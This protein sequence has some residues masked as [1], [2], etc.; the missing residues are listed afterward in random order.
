MKRNPF[1]SPLIQQS[2]SQLCHRP[3]VTYCMVYHCTKRATLVRLLA[4]K[5]PVIYV[6]HLNRYFFIPPWYYLVVIFCDKAIQ[7]ICQCIKSY[8]TID[9]ILYRCLPWCNHMDYFFVSYHFI[10]LMAQSAPHWW[11]MFFTQQTSCLPHVFL[12]HS[13]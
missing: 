7:N 3:V 4:N 11:G 12:I 2:L 5:G 6:V 8:V 1:L 10:Y 13:S 9:L